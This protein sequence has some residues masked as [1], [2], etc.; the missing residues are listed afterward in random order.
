MSETWKLGGSKMAAKE[1]WYV[2]DKETTVQGMKG[3]IQCDKRLNLKGGGV[4]EPRSSN[5]KK[6]VSCYTLGE[7]RERVECGVCEGAGIREFKDWHT[8]LTKKGLCIYCKSR[9]YIWKLG[10]KK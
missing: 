8:S 3:I 6:T 2:W 9:G 10:E 7:T 4:L 1:I 5:A